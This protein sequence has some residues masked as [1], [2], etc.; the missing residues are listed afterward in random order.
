MLPMS[1]NLPLSNFHARAVIV[2][3]R[4]LTEIIGKFEHSIRVADVPADQS[5][6]ADIKAEH[7]AIRRM[8][9]QHRRAQIPTGYPGPTN[10]RSAVTPH[11]EGSHTSRTS[12][13]LYDSTPTV[14]TSL[15]PRPARRARQARPSS[16]AATARGAYG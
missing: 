3:E 15:L 12:I 9:E 13:S 2:Y 6:P 16:S 7:T 14:N 11:R 10:S 5:M 8:L 1:I 4:E